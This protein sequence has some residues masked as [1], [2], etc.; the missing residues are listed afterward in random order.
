MS[1]RNRTVRVVIG[2]TAALQALTPASSG[3]D[4]AATASAISPLID[5]HEQ[6]D[7]LI[8]EAD[9]P[10][11]SPETLSVQLEDNVL[12]LRAS[13]QSAVPESCRMIHEEFHPGEFQRSFILGDD[14]DRDRVSA[15]LKNGVLRLHL[16][17]AERSQTRKIEIR[18][19]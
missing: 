4:R 14:V 19:S 17:K 5:I 1:A 10:G 15:E 2:P 11:A 7:G 3:A 8:L 13:A 18:S 12:N 6:A 16:P 9:L